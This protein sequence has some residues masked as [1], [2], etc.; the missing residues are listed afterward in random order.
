MIGQALRGERAERATGAETSF[1]MPLAVA[2][3]LLPPGSV[4]GSPDP[5]AVAGDTIEVDIPN[6]YEQ[7]AK[8][9]VVIRAG[10]LAFFIPSHLLAPAALADSREIVLPLKDVVSAVG[11]AALGRHTTRKM[12][13]YEKMDQLRDPF[14]AAEGE[15]AAT[16]AR[17]DAKPAAGWPTPE[18]G[19]PVVPAPGAAP[20]SRPAVPAA[21]PARV[22]KAASLAVR[23]GKPEP[24]QEVKYQ[25]LPGNV[26][27]NTADVAEL[28]TLGGVSEALALRI[29]EYRRD[30]GPFKSVFDLCRVPRL[31]RKTFRRMTGMPFS[32]R[33]LHRIRHLARLLRI[34]CDRVTDLS[35]IARAIAGRPGF[36]GCAISDPDGLL[37]AQGAAGE[38]GEDLSAIVPRTVRQVQESMNAIEAGR[39]D[40]ISICSE[41]RMYTVVSFRGVAL[42]AIHEERRI[43][44]KQLVLIR[45]IG[46]ELAWLLSHRA[47]VA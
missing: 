27:V 38:I 42:A 35:A 46:G 43:T 20:E 26:N 33:H 4:K 45:K 12:R 25:E 8:G 3:S 31:G 14:T 32:G 29:L 2:L 30:H 19:G 10:S 28:R 23:P 5:A 41:G 24:D 11:P 44:K 47:Y 6:L 22:A 13:R 16:R 17:A 40:S 39:V 7:L 36:S 21:P 1:P 34:P 15:P 37:L 9:R 18:A